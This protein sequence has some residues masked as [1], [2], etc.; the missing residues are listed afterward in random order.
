[1]RSTGW[2]GTQG[3]DDESRSAIGQRSW[4]TTGAGRDES[5]ASRN[6]SDVLWSSGGAF[7]N[8]NDALWNGSVRSR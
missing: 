7:R 2:R 4:E 1:M 3:N 5:D 6:G 8:R